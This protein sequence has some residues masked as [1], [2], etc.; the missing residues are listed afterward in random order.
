MLNEKLEID[1]NAIYKFTFGPIK[2][3]CYVVKNKNEIVVID[4]STVG[5]NEED[6]LISF[7]KLLNG[8]LYYIIN[9]HGHFDHIAGNTALKNT[10]PDA[11]ILIHREDREKLTSPEKNG[12]KKFG[13]RTIS[14]DCDKEL[15]NGDK[16]SFGKTMLEVIHI[17]GHTEGS[18][19][20]KGKGFIFTGD[21][22]FA[23]TVGITK[24][25][26]NVFNK[27]IKTIKEKILT[28]GDSYIILPGHMENSTIKE[29]KEFNP[30]LK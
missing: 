22:L 23:G 14:P 28:L 9:T 15:E 30:F 13:L 25:Y 2:T 7:L 24:E 26:R 10:F 16:I 6:K 5:K 12:S 8:E 18:I 29:E 11:K 4:P 1:E 20:L 19:C 3:N 21:I 27:M 17:P